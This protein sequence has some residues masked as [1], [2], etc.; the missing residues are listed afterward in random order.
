MDATKP[1]DTELVSAL[2]AYLRETRAAINAISGSGD[3]GITDLTIGAGAVALTVGTEV[4]RY[5][6]EVVRTTA[7]GAVA[8]AK[9]LGGTDG[10]VKKFIFGD[11]NTSLTDGVASGGNLY[12]NQLPA[13]SSFATQANDAI[14]LVNIGGDGGVTTHGYWQEVSRQVALK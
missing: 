4:G 12:L 13:L 7:V 5:G 8:I 6:Y 3:V 14:E 1:N 11:N 10:Q 9:I 2:P